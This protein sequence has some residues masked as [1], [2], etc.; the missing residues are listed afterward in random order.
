MRGRSALEAR[1]IVHV[2]VERLHG[3]VHRVA[4]HQVEAAFLGLTGED[5]DAHV[6]GFLDLG[7][8]HRQHREAAGDVEPA[9]RHREAALQELAGEVDG[10]RELVGLDAHEADEALAAAA[11]DLGHEV[12]GT[13]ARIGLVDRMDDDVDVRT[14][15]FPPT[16]I[17]AEAV[18]R[19]QSIGRDMRPEP[20]DRI[21]VI[22]VMSRLDQN[23]MKLRTLHG[24]AHCGLLQDIIRTRFQ[25]T[26]A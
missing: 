21:A 13:D 12:V 9:D 7:R 10:V 1:Q 4:Q 18:E 6:H 20:R 22:I 3:A 5:R 2:V 19:S 23:Q 14:Q 11:L 16:A 25:P 24:T 8:R 15:H 17:L 26:T